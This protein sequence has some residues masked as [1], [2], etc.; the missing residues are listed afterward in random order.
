MIT[1]QEYLPKLAKAARL[2]LAESPSGLSG[3]E[4][5]EILRAAAQCHICLTSKGIQSQ[6]DYAESIDN[7][8]PRNRK[9]RAHFHRM[10]CQFEVNGIQV[11][12]FN[13]S[14]PAQTL[15]N[16]KFTGMSVFQGLPDQ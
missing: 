4:E 6:F 12:Y 1:A 10:V 13:F 3:Q 7:G 2:V 5:T 11:H 14:S 16:L 9:H 15:G 8:Q